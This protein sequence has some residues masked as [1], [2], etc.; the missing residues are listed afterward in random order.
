MD[1]LEQLSETIDSTSN[2][3]LDRESF[4][5]GRWRKIHFERDFELRWLFVV[6]QK[7]PKTSTRSSYPSQQQKLDFGA[8]SKTDKIFELRSF[9]EHDGHQGSQ[10]EQSEHVS[11]RDVR[12]FAKRV[13]TRV[14]SSKIEAD[15]ILAKFFYQC[16][17]DGITEQASI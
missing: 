17:R 6:S 2:S 8:W 12:A 14:I 7:F 5:T 9:K 3:R 16:Q 15:E 4:E 10:L 13:A 11:P 1:S